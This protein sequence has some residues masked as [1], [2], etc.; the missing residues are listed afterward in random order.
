MMLDNN[1]LQIFCRVVKCKSFSAAAND[2]F[3]S[4]ATVSTRIK[5]L[6]EQVGT[7]LLHRNK[8]G[9]NLTECGNIL[10]QY[11]ERILSLELEA[12]NALLNF[13]SGKKGVLKLAGSHTLYDFLF[14]NILQDFGKR[15]RDVEV[16]LSS[17]F[18][19][20]TIDKV[21]DGT[22]TFGFARMP[23]PHF[24]DTRFV[25]KLISQDRTYFFAS[26]AHHIFQYKHI[27]MERLA[28]MPIVAYGCETNY[29]PQIKSLFE[30]KGL[31]LNVAMEMN[32]NQSTKKMVES[33]RHI[34]YLPGITIKTEVAN[35]TLK[36]IP[37]EDLPPIYRYT[38]F[39]YRKDSMLFGVDRAFV[40]FIDSMDV[41]EYDI[42]P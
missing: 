5:M 8:R 3:M 38:F 22:A 16:S 30:E 40:D 21:A 10:Y 6:E 2:L 29:W 9:V 11:A 19:D 34:S 17:G 7:Q 14:P 36:V 31:R 20:Q 23:S 28:Q 25:S 15:H 24:Y 13:R 26:P 32:D 42:S 35:G 41:V 4:Q 37:V 12:E 39:I 33:G 1:D 18:T 27:T